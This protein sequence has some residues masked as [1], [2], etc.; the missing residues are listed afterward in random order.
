MRRNGFTLIELLVVIAIIGILAAILFPVFARA[1][2]SARKTQC[3]S[4]VKNIAMAVQIYLTDYDLLPPKEHRPEA[5]ALFE[6]GPGLEGAACDYG[7]ALNNATACNPYL[8]WPVVLEEY[9]KSREVWRCPSARRTNGAGWIVPC[10]DWLGALRAHLG[11]WGY[12]EGGGPCAGGWPPGWGGPVTD[13]FSQGWASAEGGSSAFVQSI[14]VT[15]GQNAE[16]NPSSISDPSWFVIC[17]DSGGAGRGELGA[18]P[19]LAF[20]EICQ[21]MYGGRDRPW[22]DGGCGADWT[23]CPGTQTCA[24]DYHEERHFWSDA[25][26]RRRYTEHL[27]GSN[28]GFMDGHAKWFPADTIIAESPGGAYYAGDPEKGDLRGLGCYCT[29]VE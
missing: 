24:L 23:N 6:P 11:A 28:V 3:L 17:G 26:F 18:P 9:I 5:A 7:S 15:A 4:N 29:L 19:L 12:Y 14:G 8:R 21:T 10:P 27:G 25:S 13:S 2:E 16:L 20:P 1:R 22:W